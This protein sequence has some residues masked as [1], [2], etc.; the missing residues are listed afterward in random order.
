MVTRDDV[1]DAIAEQ[2]THWTDAGIAP[3]AVEKWIAHMQQYH[4]TGEQD[5]RK[6]L[7]IVRG[8]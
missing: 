1:L 8:R 7:R 4:L 5:W 6:V 2:A 3:E